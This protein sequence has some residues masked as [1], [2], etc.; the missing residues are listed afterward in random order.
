MKPNVRD[1]LIYLGVGVGIVSLIV[2]DLIYS[3]IRGH[4]MWWPSRAA[5]R[6]VYTA[7]LLSYFVFR[8]AKRL[9]STLTQALTCV[10]LAD[11]V[12][13]ALVYVFRHNVDTVSG[14]SFAA[15]GVFEMFLVFN[16]AMALAHYLRAGTTTS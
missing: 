12:H 16:L 8:E 14:I 13:L 7:I 6:G 3:N 2:A 11:I 1:N 4:A 10:L 15:L 5:A 9:R